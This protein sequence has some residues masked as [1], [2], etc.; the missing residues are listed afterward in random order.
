MTEVILHYSV[1][2]TVHVDID[3]VSGV[4]TRGNVTHVVVVGAGIEQSEAIPEIDGTVDSGDPAY[5]AAWEYAEQ[6]AD[7]TRWPAWEIKYG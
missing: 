4:G 3:M 2:V 6:V 5:D 7:L 1:P